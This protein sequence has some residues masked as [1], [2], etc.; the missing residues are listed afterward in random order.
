MNSDERKFI[1]LSFSVYKKAEWGGGRGPSW[2]R[3]ADEG[4]GECYEKVTK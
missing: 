1:T 3:V 2:M 4:M